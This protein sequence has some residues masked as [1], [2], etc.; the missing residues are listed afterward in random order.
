ME[1]SHNL[2]NTSYSYT[3]LSITILCEYLVPNIAL[4]TR[5]DCLRSI[6]AQLLYH[7]EIL[8]LEAKGHN[9]RTYAYIPEVDPISGVP[10]HEREDHNHVLKVN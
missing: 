2:A 7:Y 6:I 1:V 9:F 3:T 4:E 10:F 8:T 5:K